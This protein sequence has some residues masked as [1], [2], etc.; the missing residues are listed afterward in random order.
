[1][2]QELQQQFL[3]LL[4]CGCAAEK[5]LILLNESGGSMGPAGQGIRKA[6]LIEYMRA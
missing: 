5:C 4:G 6:V 3:H 2:D 1:M